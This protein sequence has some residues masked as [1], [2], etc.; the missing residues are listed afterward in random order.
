MEIGVYHIHAVLWIH[1]VTHYIIA[2][3]MYNYR[4]C[5]NS[6]VQLIQ[7]NVQELLIQLFTYLIKI[8]K[9]L[10]LILNILGTSILFLNKFNANI[11]SNFHFHNLIKRLMT[12]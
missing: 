9:A 12:Y 4:F 6:H 8:Q 11:S 10:M 7:Q 5:N 2:L 3:Q 1:C